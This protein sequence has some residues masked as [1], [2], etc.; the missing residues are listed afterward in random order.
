[1]TSKTR[2]DWV[3]KM[4]PW[5]L[6]KKFKFDYTN[7]WYMHSLEP[8]LENEMQKLLLDFKIKTDHLNSARIDPQMKSD[9]YTNSKWC[10]WYN[11]RRINKETGG[12]GNKRTSRDHPN[13]SL[14]YS[15]HSR[16]VHFLC[17]FG[18]SAEFNFSKDANKTLD[19]KKENAM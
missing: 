2:H 5:E 6:C 13:N 1:M 19:K 18:G 4:I 11:H 9:S 12:L 7:K 17:L 16:C 8:V 3:G 14:S 15:H 10:F